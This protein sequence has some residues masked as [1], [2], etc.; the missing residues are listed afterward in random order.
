[1]ILAALPEPLD[2]TTVK[3]SPAPPFVIDAATPLPLE[4]FIT[5]SLADKVC[6]PKSTFAVAPV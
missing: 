4:W 6:V 2:F 1:V 5:K 3:A